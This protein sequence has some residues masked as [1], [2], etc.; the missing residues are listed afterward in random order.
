MHKRR[1]KQSKGTAG[2]SVSPALKRPGGGHGDS[3]RP[4]LPPPYGPDTESKHMTFKLKAETGG[5]V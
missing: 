2:G 5:R 4:F 3:P 1:C